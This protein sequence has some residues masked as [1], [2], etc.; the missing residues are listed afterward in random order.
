MQQQK[1]IGGTVHIWS[2]I[3]SMRTSGYSEYWRGTWPTILRNV[4][5]NAL[6]FL[7][8]D[9]T[10]LRLRQF[11]WN[12]SSNQGLSDGMVNLIG[13]SASRA[14]A[15]ALLMPFTVMKTRFESSKYNY[16][17][18]WNASRHILSQEGIR[19]LFTGLVATTLRYLF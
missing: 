14:F 19:G 10:R 2:T 16:T 3:Q 12:L 11:R 5:G 8:L 7:I 15:G 17:G 18:V 9:S 1:R 13:G 4:P 6:Y